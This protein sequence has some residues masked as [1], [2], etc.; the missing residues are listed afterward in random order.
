MTLSSVRLTLWIGPSVPAPAPPELMASLQSVE[1]TRQSDVSG[2]QLAFNA[3]R[4]SGVSPELSLLNGSL[5]QPGSRVLIM[6]S[7]GALPQVL[8]D[9]IITHQQLTPGGNGETLLSVTG[10]DISVMMDLLDL[11]MEYPGLGDMEIALMVLA[12]Y[13]A[14]GIIPEVIPTPTSLAS[15]PIESTPQQSGT[16]RQYLQSLAS[17]HGYVFFV[18]PGP[19]PMTNIAYWGPVDR[20]GLP[21]K[22]INVDLGP[23]TNV[24][25]INFAYNAL[26]PTQVYG[27]VSDEDMETILPVLTITGLRPPPLSSRPPLIFNQPFVRKQ[28]LDYQGS[29]WIEAQALAQSITDRSLDDAVTATGSLNVLRYGGLLTS[30]GLVG[31]RGAGFSYDGLYYVKSVTYRIALGQVS[32]EFTL[33]REGVGSTVPGVTP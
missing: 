12:K 16:D 24:E 23:A 30:P 3:R 28:M 27:A 17:R 31:V 8:M 5:L 18:R 33:T 10:E 20:T 15:L 21:Q 7:L 9:G 19:A 2:F 25:T 14:L 1:V 11:P 4:S 6:L 22:T 13:A 32:Q 29:S 26:A